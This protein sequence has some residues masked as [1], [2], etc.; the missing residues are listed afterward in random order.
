MAVNLRVFDSPCTA[1]PDCAFEDFQDDVRRL[2][3]HA[4][5]YVRCVVGSRWSLPASRA[6]TGHSVRGGC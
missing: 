6:A 2:L 1:S 3:R 4:I 5:W